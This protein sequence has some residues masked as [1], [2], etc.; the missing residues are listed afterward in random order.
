MTRASA[1][2]AGE[3]VREGLG[4]GA[5]LREQVA[6]GTAVGTFLIELPHPRAVRALALAGLDFV[7]VDMEHSGCD[8]DGT[9]LTVGSP[10]SFSSTPPRGRTGRR[11]APASTPLRSTTAPSGPSDL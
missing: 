5:E 4:R 11:R 9:Y 3:L 6:Q 7:V 8:G 10:F 2:C 1:A